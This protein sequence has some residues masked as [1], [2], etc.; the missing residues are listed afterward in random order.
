MNEE[1]EKTCWEKKLEENMKNG[2]WPSHICAHGQ[3]LKNQSLEY[4][5]ILVIPRNDTW[6]FGFG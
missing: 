1:D 5:N 6:G 3:T 4:K 2:F